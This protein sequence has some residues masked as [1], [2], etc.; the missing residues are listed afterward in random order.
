M[1]I[2]IGTNAG[3]KVIA[4][5]VVGTAS[6]N[7]TVLNAYV[8]TASG[9][10]LVYSSFSASASPTSATG[11]RVG[12]GVATTS[13]ATTATPDG[14][15][16]PYTYSWARVSGDASITITQPLAATTQFT[17]SLTSGQSKAAAFACTVTD[18]GSGLVEVTNAVNVVLED[19]GGG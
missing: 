4:N 16:G 6:G 1:P 15:I 12:A 18:T 5:V 14:G 3:N 9:N 7:K 2:T 17:T 11:F 10:E 13:P 19:I 8:G